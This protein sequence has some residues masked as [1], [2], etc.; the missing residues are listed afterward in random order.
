MRKNNV[1]VVCGSKDGFF[2]IKNVRAQQACSSCET[3]SHCVCAAWVLRSDAV[4]RQGEL[5]ASG[6]LMGAALCWRGVGSGQCR[7]GTWVPSFPKLYWALHSP[8]LKPLLLPSCLVTLPLPHLLP[9]CPP[10]CPF[11]L[12]PGLPPAYL[13]LRGRAALPCRPGAGDV[14]SFVLLFDL[15]LSI[16]MS[17]LSS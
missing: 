12:F 10:H 16:C 2:I 14:F 8:V 9:A 11:P 3:S 4:G 7:P 13:H 15:C 1:D 17:L 6:R 5:Q